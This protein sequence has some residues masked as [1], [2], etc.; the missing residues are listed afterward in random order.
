MHYK[1]CISYIIKNKDPKKNPKVREMVAR[2]TYIH[3]LNLYVD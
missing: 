2:Y 1:K 3:D